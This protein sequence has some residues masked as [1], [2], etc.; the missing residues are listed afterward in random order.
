M[1]PGFKENEEKGV[2]LAIE[3]EYRTL[4]PIHGFGLWD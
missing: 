4:L 1:V 3:V 2:L